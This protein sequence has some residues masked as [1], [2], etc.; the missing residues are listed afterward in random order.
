M[1]MVGFDDAAK[2]FKYDPQMD[3]WPA[4]WYGDSG[5]LSNWY[6][7]NPMRQGRDFMRCIGGVE[8]P[9]Y[10]VPNGYM[11]DVKSFF[12]GAVHGRVPGDAKNSLF[13]SLVPGHMDKKP[14]PQN[15][16]PAGET[17]STGDEGHNNQPK[18]SSSDSGGC[19]CS[20]PGTSVPGG[21]AAGVG[22]ALALVVIARRRKQE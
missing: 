4:A 22:A 17:P 1:M 13:L 20:T 15:P 18:N 16:I 12:V 2:Q 14:A 21:L 19:G 3:L 5:H 9:G 10:H 11:A 6:G 7:R 8:N